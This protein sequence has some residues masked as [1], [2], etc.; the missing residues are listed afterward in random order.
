MQQVKEPELTTP[1]KR[2]NAEVAPVRLV[3]PPESSHAP[4]PNAFRRIESEFIRRAI[5]PVFDRRWHPNT[6]RY[7]AELRALEFSSLDEVIERQWAKLKTMVDYAGANVPYYK[8]TFRQAGIAAGDIRSF[9][10]YRRVPVLRK[11]TLQGRQNDLI[12]STR[13]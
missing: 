10:D 1:E 13:R 7:L 12:S 8:D 2:G 6:Q 5:F 3:S 11:S 9:D 4:Q